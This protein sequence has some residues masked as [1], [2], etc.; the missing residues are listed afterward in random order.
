MTENLEKNKCPSRTLFIGVG[1]V[2]SKIIR[3]VADK[4][5]NTDTTNIKF[6]VMDTDVNDLRKL[7]D[8]APVD[9]RA[10]QT[11]STQTVGAYLN[12][13]VDASQQWFPKNSILYNK[14]VSEGAGQ[15]RAISR[16]A[17]NATIRQ[18]NIKPLYNAIDE[19]F[20]KDGRDL[21]QALRIYIV[22]TSAGGTGSG[23]A[24]GVSQLIRLYMTQN[25]PESNCMIRGM[26]I[27]PGVLDTVITSEK[28]RNSIRRNGYATIKEINAFMMLGSRFFEVDKD[29]SRYRD[30]FLGFP[31][32]E[33]QD[34]S[35]R[36]LPFDFCFLLDRLDLNQGNMKNLSQYID[37][38][39]Q[40]LFEQNIGPMQGKAFSVEDNIVKE[41]ADK[42]MLGRN[43]FGAIGAAV[44]QYP[45]ETIANYVAK[46]WA[47]EQIGGESVTEGWLQYD[48]EYLRLM[49]EYRKHGG[50]RETPPVRGT[51]YVD[52][53]KQSESKLS[54]QLRRRYLGGDDIDAVAERI[55]EEI[56]DYFVRLNRVLRERLMGIPSY[57]EQYDALRA[58]TSKAHFNNEMNR[59]KYTSYFG[60]IDDYASESRKSAA[61]TGK[62]AGNAIFWDEEMRVSNNIQEYAVESILKAEDGAIHPNAMR[63]YLYSLSDAFSKRIEEVE[64]IIKRAEETMTEFAPS[65]KSK[66][67]KP[68]LSVK[69]GSDVGD[70]TRQDVLSDESK[71]RSCGWLQKRKLKPLYN[72]LAK[73]AAAYIKAID[74]YAENAAR[75]KAYELGKAYILKVVSAFE[76]FYDKFPGKVKKLHVQQEDLEKELEFSNGD[77]VTR[78]CATKELLREIV[79]RCSQN[80]DELLPEQLNARIYNA[81][82]RNVI[83]ERE[84]EN[85]TGIV[86]KRT[87]VFDQE[88]LKFFEKS[89]RDNCKDILDKN[90]L[91]AIQW[92]CELKALIEE[93][94]KYDIRGDLSE[95]KPNAVSLDKQYV[96]KYIASRISEGKLLASPGISI[97]TFTEPRKVSEC[98]FNEEL[99]LSRTIKVDDYINSSA[100][101]SKSVSKYELH[102]FEALYNIT[103]DK[104]ARFAAKKSSETGIRDAGI[105]FDAYQDYMKGVGPDSTKSMV[106]SPH[107]D[108]RW[109]TIAVMPEIDM[110]YQK[111]SFKRIHLAMF[112]GIVYGLI[113]RRQITVYNPEKK[114]FQLE[115][116]DGEF[117]D[118]IVSNGS[119]CDEFYEVLDS[120]Y[121]DRSAV[122]AI[123]EIADEYRHKDE[124]KHTKFDDTEFV[125]HV[126]SLKLD[127][128]D[129]QDVDDTAVDS[130]F[131][132]PLLYYKSIP[133]SKRDD[134][135]LILMI[136]SVIDA[137]KNEIRVFD[138]SAD[139]LSHLTKLMG[140]QFELLRNGY[141]S[142][143]DKFL[144]DAAI[145]RSYDDNDV[146]KWII[147]KLKELTEGIEANESVDSENKPIESP[148][149][150]PEYKAK[151]DNAEDSEPTD[152]NSDAASE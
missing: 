19:L 131:A 128:F 104:L 22:S 11:S 91:E 35:L 152:E 1:G 102:F 68:P 36:E 112:Y 28:E 45:Y 33:G 9:I 83:L 113:K 77:S 21:K 88:I 142:N 138:C 41:A 151:S 125:K 117:K 126:K 130:V 121:R 111:E 71:Y 10:I 73:W 40:S 95:E 67:F 148:A 108:K 62:S 140:D 82:K 37:Y 93:K 13:D 29:L 56:S 92:E 150:E 141:H 53:L 58:L 4:C 59:G 144:Q 119:P 120:L 66:K 94:R 105:Y 129:D 109:D 63:A 146:V 65:T 139:R 26:L 42:K 15:V 106:I 78:I 47:I 114:Y 81:L 80:A 99:K 44:V 43:R 96:S 5:D 133:N 107:I 54:A 84:M 39:A 123:L 60:K 116:K 55:D 51:V 50:A 69:K 49:N 124:E 137:F 74:E 127:Y 61:S 90:I 48:R 145:S 27:L 115:S 136:E 147:R 85:D 64:E 149:T 143:L 76:K 135:E 30:L 14:T 70:R 72:E 31:V 132:I 18:G 2:G 24:M 12:Y 75:L 86:D 97:A 17:L 6:V 87:D 57:K 79:E 16:L 8:G 3:L 46:S 98:A 110:E 134:S 103:P 118:L 23:I 52:K 100:G 32:P 38:A 122:E 7:R 25:Y 101:A 34:V 20:A 89:V